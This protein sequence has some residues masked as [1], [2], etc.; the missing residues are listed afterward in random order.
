MTLSVAKSVAIVAVVG[1]AACAGNS[2]P[3]APTGPSTPT[4][5]APAPPSPPAPV[6]PPAT[7]AGERWNLMMTFLTV[8]GPQEC[9]SDTRAITWGRHMAVGQ[10]AAFLPDH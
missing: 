4:V 6:P 5:P 8:T 1:A 9:L 10:S 7:L 3:V 2:L